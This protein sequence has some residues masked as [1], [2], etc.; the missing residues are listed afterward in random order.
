MNVPAG[1]PIRVFQVATGNVG[2]EMIKRLGARDDLELVGV[3]CYSPEKVGKDVGE[4]V[5]IG[6][7][8]RDG[9]R[10]GRG[11]HRRQARRADLPRCVP[12]RGP[13][14]AGPRGGYRHRHHRRLDHGLAPRHQSPA[15][16]GQARVATAEGGLR[17]RRVD[18]LRH[19]DEP[20]PQPDPRRG[21]LGRR[22]RD[23]ER[24]HHRIGR[25]VVSSLQGHLDRGR[26]RTARRRPE[27][28]R[29]VGEVHPRLRRQRADDGRLL[30]PRT[31]RG[32]VRLRAR[33]LHQG[34]RPGRGTSC[35]RA[36]WAA[37]TSST[38]ASWTECRGSRHTSSGR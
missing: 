8:R 3:H 37:T 23:R 6:P 28:A 20:G 35:P 24:H 2:S 13:L 38:R 17:E 10:H 7:N 27:P 25:R 32:E 1:P 5:G 12:R 30:R 36:R 33:R 22:R 4:L 31:R 11:D 29:Q 9:H 15:P 21:L 26:L 14:R 19:R 16:V 18:V 34:R